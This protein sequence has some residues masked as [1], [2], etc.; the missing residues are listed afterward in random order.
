MNAPRPR[1]KFSTAIRQAL[2]GRNETTVDL[3]KAIN[4]P[5][6]TVRTWLNRQRF[7]RAKAVAIA[8]HLGL[9]QVA[10]DI[11]HAYEVGWAQPIRPQP[12][13]GPPLDFL[14]LFREQEKAA[15]RLTEL[16]APAESAL[17]AMMKTMQ[18]GDS[19][20]HITCSEQ[21]PETL[22]QHA[23]MR[24]TIAQAMQCGAYFLYVIASRQLYHN[25][26]RSFGIRLSNEHSWIGDAL[27]A[28]LRKDISCV[29]AGRGI[30]PE[31]ARSAVR[32]QL[33][34]L[35]AD[36]WP[37]FAVGSSYS[38][39]AKVSD[40]TGEPI[41]RAFLSLPGSHGELLTLPHQELFCLRIAAAVLRYSRNNFSAKQLSEIAVFAYLLQ[42]PDFQN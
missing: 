26:F 4:A 12:H 19:Y 8:T 22:P 11:E 6:S 2:A 29:L 38:L 10:A 31:E 15:I 16:T 40:I 41:F 37:W 17:V 24:E 7:P 42:H 13:K 27:T 23:E 35:S 32:R 1:I 20:F 5:S 28:V 3:A 39:F 21:P 9:G 14:R 30:P 34:I 33:L 36:D 18:R 25:W